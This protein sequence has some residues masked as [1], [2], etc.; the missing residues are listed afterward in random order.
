MVDEATFKVF[1]NTILTVRA[2]HRTRSE[3]TADYY[4][5]ALLDRALELELRYDE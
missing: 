2:I 5:E 3:Q 4:D 1:R